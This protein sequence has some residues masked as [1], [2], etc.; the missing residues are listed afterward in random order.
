MKRS[1]NP[2]ILIPAVAG[3]LVGILANILADTLAASGRPVILALVAIT[4][5]LLLLTLVYRERQRI[6]GRFGLP[7]VIRTLV[8]R[9]SYSQRGLIAIVSLYNPDKESP[10]AHLTREERLAAAA[11][12]DYEMLCLEQSNYRP[13]IFAVDTHTSRLVHCWLIATQSDN[14]ATSSLTCVPILEKYLR[15]QKGVKYTFH[16]G[17]QYAL[18]LQDD[19]LLAERTRNLVDRIFKEAT[20]QEIGLQE[21]E[22]I[23]DITGG[24]CS[25]PL[26]VIVAC[27]DRRR[28][29]QFIGAHYDDQARPTHPLF[30]IL[31][32]YTAEIP[33]E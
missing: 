4:A 30:P 21:Q 26:G 7:I 14:P 8:D 24:F 18:V 25:L 6:T 29:V 33:Q 5:L 13:L 1:L 10:A 28:K 16:S 27:L 9:Y 12:L 22:I 19:A 23:A 17:E 20:D 2:T 31:F 3:F 32:E 15:E 11:A